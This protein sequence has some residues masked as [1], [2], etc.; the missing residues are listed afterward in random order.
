M[1]KYL[2]AILILGVLFIV[3]N[4]VAAA[5]R[6]GTKAYGMGGA[7]T[8]IAD[9]ASAIYWNPAGLT[10][11]SLVG[12]QVSGGGQMDQED[13]EEIADFIDAVEK[14]KANPSASD[15]ENIELPS[16]TTAN[17]NG[18]AALNLGK[19][20][21]GGVFNSRFNFDEGKKK[22]YTEGGK[23]Y[24]LPQGTA[25]NYFTGQ[26]ILGLGSKVIDPP[27]VGS[28]SVG[29]SGKYLYARHDKAETVVDNNNNTLTTDYTE[30]DDNGIGADVGM[31][32]TLTDTDV[33]NL[34]AGATVKN[35]INTMDME[36]DSLERTTTIGAG[37][38]FKFP[39]IEAFS[40]RL[41]ADLEMPEDGAD[42]RR[43]GFEGTMGMFSLRAGTYD[44]DNMEDAVY[45]G[46]VGFNLPFVDFNLTM[47]SED[48][49][50][51]SGT[52]NF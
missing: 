28:L 36:T 15:L 48:Y 27:I 49:I 19:M 41:A 24:K 12:L 52:F 46:G 50:S 6:Y 7:F 45:T 13:I 25:D 35:I 5:S 20:G 8:A 43:F 29:V 31:L 44:S 9:D 3:A 21:L 47:D 2:S 26:G 17:I 51:A 11:N 34:K 18:I 23:T 4:P 39:V 1:K 16:D 10:Q 22:T 42:I 30:E 40:T 32:A 38:T 33:L 37:A 14:L